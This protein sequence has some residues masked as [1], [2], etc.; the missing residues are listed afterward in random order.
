MYMKPLRGMYISF[1]EGGGVRC[2]VTA[3]RLL[4]KTELI[5]AAL[6]SRCGHYIL[7]CCFF[8]FY[9][10]FFFFSSPT[11]R[12]R[13]LDVYHTVYFH[14]WCDLSANLGCR[15]ETCCTR[16]AENTGRKKI[17]K[18]SSSGHHRTTLSGYIFATKAQSEKSYLNSNISSIRP[19]YGKLQPTNGWDRF[20]YLGHPTKCQPVL[21]L[22]SV[23]ARHSSSRRQPNFAA[24]NRGRHL[25]LAGRP[26]RWV[27]AHIIVLSIMCWRYN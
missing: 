18:N 21:R 12:P 26:S 1:L 17:V 8:F 4:K 16:L 3:S 7:P 20:G 14:T 2:Y 22:G 5:V 9:L 13:R 10:S 15:S 24:L 25:Y 27:L 19:Q 23:T 11:V 6:R